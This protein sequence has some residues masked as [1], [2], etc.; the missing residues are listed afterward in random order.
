MAKPMAMKE[1]V[2]KNQ[3]QNNCEFLHVQEK[4]NCENNG[5]F[6]NCTKSI[7][8]LKTNGSLKSCAYWVQTQIQQGTKMTI[9]LLFT[10]FL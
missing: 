8:P 9:V 2:K 7:V 10:L 5:A 1:I 6:G 3:G 4:N